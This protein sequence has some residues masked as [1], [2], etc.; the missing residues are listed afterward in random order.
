[1]SLKNTL[2]GY[3]H[4]IMRKDVVTSLIIGAASASIRNIEDA[5]KEIVDNLF[6]VDRATWGLVLFEKELGIVT[7][8]SLGFEARRATIKAKSRGTGKLS[9][10]LIDSV[11]DAWKRADVHVWFEDGVIKIKFIDTGGV[12][13]RVEDLQAMIE[14]IK[15]AHLPVEFIY[16]YL[17]AGVFSE[18]NLT[19]AEFTRAN[20]TGPEW[21]TTLFRPV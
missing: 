5:L 13:D 7:D 19:A 1:M 11:C 21:N 16:S 18:W 20:L 3:L 12:P 8:K 17:L 4:K 14:D 15:P 6:F 9:L 2:L 10:E